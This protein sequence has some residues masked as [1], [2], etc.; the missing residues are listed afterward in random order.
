[1]TSAMPQIF[2]A[3]ILVV[4]GQTLAKLGMK[5]IGNI[6][7]S[8]GLVEFYLKAFLNP[9][10]F[11]GTLLY[12]SAVFFWLYVLSKVELSYAYPFLALTYILV[13]LAAWLVLGESIPILRWIGLFVICI[14]VF[15]VAKSY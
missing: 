6:D 10:I 7:T 4:A 9:Y 15:L 14:G 8:G 5:T 1:M 2:A 11:M 13:I 12:G 3:V